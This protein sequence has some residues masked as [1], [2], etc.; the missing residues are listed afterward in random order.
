MFSSRLDPDLS[1]GRLQ[2]ALDQLRAD[3]APLID[4]TC[5]NPPQCRLGPAPE[6]LASALA[7]PGAAEY[8]PDPRGMPGAR[9]A[10]A[11][12]YADRGLPTRPD[13]IFLS[14]STS[15]SY[16]E[17]IKLFCD[18]GDE[19]L[20]PQPSYPLFDMLVSLEGCRPVRF[21]SVHTPEGRWR[22]DERELERAFT[23]RT[24]AVVLV[25]PNNPTGTY[26]AP[27]QYAVIQ[28]LC[29]DRRCPILLDE[30]F[31]DYPAEGLGVPTLDEASGLT[32]RLSG[33][34]KVI[35]A[36]QLKLGWIRLSGDDA[37]VRA[38]A[39]RLEF[40]ADAY[41][42]ASTP[43][44]LAAQALLPARGPIQKKIAERLQ[45]NQR[46]AKQAF[47]EGPPRLLPR[48]GG[49]YLVLRLPEAEDEEEL[50][51]QLL[52]D[53]QVVVHPGFFYDFPEGDHLVLSLLPPL[54]EFAGGV[55]RVAARIAA[56]SR[57]LRGQG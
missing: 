46:A 20:V 39:A 7:A 41:L 56:R 17:L 38:A 35:G 48:E 4:L 51:R 57:G 52:V 53:D 10:V 34:S 12:Y 25:T 21:P 9:Q 13:D 50:A 16:A 15:Q 54:E 31:H 28:Q 14:A 3:G 26:L 40:I 11:R 30:V 18:P 49:W 27:E 29:S 19:I 24:R 8:H 22:V 44:Q 36:P 32:V 43:A 45:A 42:S 2:Q 47:G 5:S 33:L 37:L 1:P 55:S 6:L 23:S